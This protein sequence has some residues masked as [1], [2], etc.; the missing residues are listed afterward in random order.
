MRGAAYR[1]AILRAAR[2]DAGGVHRPD[3]ELDT[4]G[5]MAVFFFG[6][7]ATFIALALEPPTAGKA[8]LA[9]HPRYRCRSAGRV[10]RVRSARRLEALDI[11]WPVAFIAG[12]GYLIW[13]VIARRPHSPA[14]DR[15][16]AG[17][18]LA[19]R[20]REGRHI[21]PLPGCCVRGGVPRRASRSHYRM[22]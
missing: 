4:S 20:A 1:W 15:M 10:L 18:A 8:P 14:P 21:A 11:L 3:S 9:V 12:G 16:P 6:I 19:L 13:R 17:A 22:G 7:A 5:A 2:P